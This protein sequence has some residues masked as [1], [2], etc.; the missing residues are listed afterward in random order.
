MRTN[1]NWI[2]LENIIRIL[3]GIIQNQLSGD[4]SGIDLIIQR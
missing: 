3:N 4:H 2:V 1:L